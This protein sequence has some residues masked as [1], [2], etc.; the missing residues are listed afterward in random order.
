MN[1]YERRLLREEGAWEKMCSRLRSSHVKQQFLP[2]DFLC[3]EC[4]TFHSGV[5]PLGV[6]VSL[7][8]RVVLKRF[9]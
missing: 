1:D 3:T 9:M 8:Y 2:D 4:N 6:V 5:L 7:S